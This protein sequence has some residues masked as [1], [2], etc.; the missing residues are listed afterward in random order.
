[1]CLAT[2]PQDSADR[3]STAVVCGASLWCVESAQQTLQR[4]ISVGKQI[5]LADQLLR[6]CMC[7]AGFSLPFGRRSTASLSHRVPC[8]GRWCAQEERAGAS[9]LA[10][11]IV[12]FP[13]SRWAGA[14]RLR[15]A[16]FVGR[17]CMAA[18]VHA[19]GVWSSILRSRED[20]GMAA[21]PSRDG[22]TRDARTH[23]R[24][25]SHTHTLSLAS[26]G[27]TTSTIALVERS[28]KTSLCG[29]IYGGARRGGLGCV[30]ALRGV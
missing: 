13:S 8:G 21:R 11:A 12:W 14:Q 17:V 2:D 24:T 22:T 3:T 9:P 15:S 29:R 19:H 27:L 28:W 6:V 18:C 20:R 4:R 10:R 7:L 25:H 26:V 5:D 30:A 1:V 23:T 16:L